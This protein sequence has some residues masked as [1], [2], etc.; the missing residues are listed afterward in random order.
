MSK[1]RQW[2][3]AYRPTTLDEVVGNAAAI[4]TIKKFLSKRNAHAILLHG[5]SG[6]GKSTLA[7]IIAKSLTDT[8]VDIKEYNIGDSRG[9]DEIRNIVSQAAYLPKGKCKV[10]VLEEVHA[11]TGPGKNAFLRPLEDPPHDKVVFILCTDRPWMLD[12]QILNRTLQIEVKLPSEDEWVDYLLGVVKNEKAFPDYS[13][14]EKRRVCKEIAL[15]SQLVPRSSLQA[16]QTVAASYK[17]YDGVKDLIVNSI[18]N[19]DSLSIDKSALLILGCIYSSEKSLADRVELLVKKATE[20]DM[21]GLL[22][23]LLF[24]N[25]NL[26]LNVCNSPTPVSNYYVRELS[27][28]KG[29]PTAGR[30]TQVGL[31]LA[32]LKSKLTTINLDPAHLI[33]PTLIDAAKQLTKKG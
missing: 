4:S 28:I 29:V 31:I 17:E 32:E 11:L 30:A 22:T 9:I 25:H 12:A 27:G 21:M 7:R 33:L 8:K 5:Q 23:R 1:E 2:A 26:L 10:Y 14:K 13:D 20:H 24:I 18:R 16:L 19:V 6:C 3:V 15:A